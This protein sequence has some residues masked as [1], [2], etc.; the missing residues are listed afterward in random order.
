ML[1]LLPLLMLLLLLL[2]RLSRLSLL[3]LL[4]EQLEDELLEC[5]CR[6]RLC[7]WRARLRE[8]GSRRF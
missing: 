2:P 3:L 5:R 7:R 8:R 1:R 4:C 6:P